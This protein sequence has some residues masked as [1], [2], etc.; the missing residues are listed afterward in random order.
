MCVSAVWLSI[1]CGRALAYATMA[2]KRATAKAGTRNQQRNKEDENACAR[3]R[4]ALKRTKKE[5]R[6]QYNKQSR[7]EQASRL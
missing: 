3:F 4:Y 7:H 2:P 5:I 1:D 6:K